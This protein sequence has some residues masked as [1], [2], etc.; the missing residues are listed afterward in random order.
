MAPK[1]QIL[2]LQVAEVGGTSGDSCI[3]IWVTGSRGD[4]F[5][6]RDDNLGRE[7]EA[8]THF[9]KGHCSKEGKRQEQ[10]GS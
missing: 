9:F 4:T 5:G 8:D 7:Q 3:K 2:K 10:E 1:I 6:A